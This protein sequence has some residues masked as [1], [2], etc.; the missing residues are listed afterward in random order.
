MPQHLIIDDKH[1]YEKYQTVQLNSI[2]FKSY[3]VKYM[4]G[5]IDPHD[6]S[7]CWD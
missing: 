5:M 7:I 6:F 1:E 2:L 4:G 3:M